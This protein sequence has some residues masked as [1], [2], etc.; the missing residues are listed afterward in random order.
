MREECFRFAVQLE[1]CVEVGLEE[2]GCGYEVF[3]F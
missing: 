2:I 3:A 1:E